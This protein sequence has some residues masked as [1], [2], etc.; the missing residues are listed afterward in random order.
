MLPAARRD[1]SINHQDVPCRLARNKKANMPTTPFATGPFVRPLVVALFST[2]TCCLA[3]PPDDSGR[4]AAQWLVA[5]ELHIEDSTD[6]FVNGWSKT[7]I[8]LRVGD[9]VGV[10]YAAGRNKSHAIR[11]LQ[12]R[13]YRFP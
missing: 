13:G 5:V 3:Q 11:P 1:D 6:V 12:I 10:C 4:T 8:E 9:R 7:L 2:A